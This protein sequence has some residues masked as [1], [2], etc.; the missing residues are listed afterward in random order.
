MSSEE[1]PSDVDRQVREILEREPPAR[2]RLVP[3]PT[4]ELFDREL[5]E[6][7]DNVLRMGMHV[8][9]AIRAAI[10]ALVRHDPDAA[11]EVITSD[12]LLNE[13]QRMVTSMITATIATQQPV[14]RDLRFLLTLDHV[15]YEL[16]RMGDHAASVAKQARR[17]AAESSLTVFGDLPAMGA[18]AADLV[19]GVLRALVDIDVEAARGVAARDD[20]VD[21]RYRRTFDDIL[22]LMRA[23][24]ANVSRGTA[25]LFAAYYLE[26]IGD[27]ATNIAED[28]VFLATGE[29]ED[30]NP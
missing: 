26:R 10:G 25:I 28:I 17:L 27:R 4:R 21:H 24:P 30:L 8:E 14:A 9:G 6:V 19:R 3:H 13:M 20:E 11:L 23:D 7:K 22:E 12:A 2:G 15:S 18:L 5:A 1:R 16:E 29:I